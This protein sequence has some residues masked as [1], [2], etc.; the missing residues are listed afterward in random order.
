M[1]GRFIVYKYFLK[2]LR[3]IIPVLISALGIASAIA[4]LTSFNF[5]DFLKEHSPQ[6]FYYLTAGILLLYLVLVIIEINRKELPR[7][8]SALD[9]NS[10]Q[11]ISTRDVKNSTFIQI[12]KDKEDYER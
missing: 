11:Y 7:Q 6:S 9:R 4:Q 12:K 10:G 3:I 8:P 5:I 1:G 2:P